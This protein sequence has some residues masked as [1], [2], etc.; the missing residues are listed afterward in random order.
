VGTIPTGQLLPD[1]AI[2]QDVWSRSAVRVSGGV[3][4]ELKLPPRTGIVMVKA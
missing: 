4:P 2:L 1:G 3:L